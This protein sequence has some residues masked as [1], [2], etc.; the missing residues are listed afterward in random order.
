MTNLWLWGP[1]GRNRIIDTEKYYFQKAYV[2]TYFGWVKKEKVAWMK[3]MAATK[4]MLAWRG[5]FLREKLVINVVWFMS[6]GFNSFG[7]KVN[8]KSLAYYVKGFPQITFS[9]LR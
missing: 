7:Q 3:G 4:I 9:R 8:N 6:F 1:T 2:Y 5:S